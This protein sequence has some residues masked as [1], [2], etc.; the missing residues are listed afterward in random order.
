VARV[1]STFNSPFCQ[2]RFKNRLRTA[3]LIIKTVPKADIRI[4][5]TDKAISGLTAPEKGW[6][7][8]RETELKGFFIVVGKRKR[9]LTVPGDLRQG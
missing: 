2:N 9:T 8:A 1:A 4:L 6:F 3:I 5:L 7:L